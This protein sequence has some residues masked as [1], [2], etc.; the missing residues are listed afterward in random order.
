MPPPFQFFLLV[1]GVLVPH[2]ALCQ[3]YDTGIM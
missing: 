2:A 3:D 1:R